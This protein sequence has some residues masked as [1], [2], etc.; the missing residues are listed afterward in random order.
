MRNKPV[1]FSNLRTC[2][3]LLARSFKFSTVSRSSGRNVLARGDGRS[4]IANL[5]QFITS[6]CAFVIPS[7]NRGLA[8]V[9]Q[10]P[11]SRVSD[12][13]HVR[14][15]VWFRSSLIRNLARGFVHDGLKN[16]VNRASIGFGARTDE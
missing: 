13:F 16:S 10:N 15:S 14:P 12:V 1:Q 8:S 9:L 4:S 5:E 2:G 7:G 3:A 6:F 11:P